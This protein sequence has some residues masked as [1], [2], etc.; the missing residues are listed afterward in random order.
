MQFETFR[1]RRVTLKRA[2]RK[3]LEY[4]K[5]QAKSYGETQDK[6]NIL[7]DSEIGYVKIENENGTMIGLI[8][9]S[10]IDDNTACIKISI[11]NKSWKEK[12]G[13]EALHQFIK[14]CKERKLYKRVY[15][16]SKNTIV[17][18]YKKERPENIKRG[19]Y[20]DIDVA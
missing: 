20:V 14:C 18:K 4:Y 1:A 15:L 9:V 17:E 3:E 2:S 11:P 8:Q 12:Y 5:E 10:K 6:L 16:K 19:M 13:T 7:K